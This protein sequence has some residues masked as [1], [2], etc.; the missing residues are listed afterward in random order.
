MTDVISEKK[1]FFR[2]FSR[3]RHGKVWT[4]C[5]IDAAEMEGAMA[6]LNTQFLEGAPRERK[7]RSS[8]T[9]D[10][11]G[12]QMGALKREYRVHISKSET[13]MLSRYLTEEV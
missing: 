13:I 1:H 9:I 2:R 4:W 5:L 11:V 6:G 7:D 10:Y 12:V 8:V 3:P